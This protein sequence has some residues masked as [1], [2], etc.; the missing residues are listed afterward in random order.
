MQE[1]L[2]FYVVPAAKHHTTPHHEDD[3]DDN[4]ATATSLPQASSIC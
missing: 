1:R 2:S 4:F 3:D